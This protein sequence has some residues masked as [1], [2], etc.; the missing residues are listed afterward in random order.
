MYLTWYATSADPVEAI[1][2]MS[3]RR[4][5]LEAEGRMD[6][7]GARTVRTGDALDL[8]NG[9]AD[10]RLRLE[11]EDLLHVGH[12]GLRLLKSRGESQVRVVPGVIAAVGCRSRFEP[13]TW[14]E[15]QLLDR[16]ASAGLEEVRKSDPRPGAMLDAGFD[17]I[18]PLHYPFLDM[19]EAS[20][21]RDRRRRD[22]RRR[23]RS[24]GLRQRRRRL[25]GP[26]ASFEAT[27]DRLATFGI[28]QA[29]HRIVDLGTGQDPCP[30]VGRLR[31]IVTG[32][33]PDI[34]LLR[35]GAGS[36]WRESR[37][38]G[39]RLQRTPVRTAGTDVVTA[40]QCW[41]WFDRRTA[42]A[43]V[44]ASEA[45]DWPISDFAFDWLP[46][47]GNAVAATEALIETHNPAWNMGGALVCGHGGFPMY[48]P[49]DSLTSKLLTDAAVPYSTSWRGRIRASPASPPSMR[50]RHRPLIRRWPRCSV[51]TSS[52]R[53][54]AHRSGNGRRSSA[55]AEAKQ[56][57]HLQ[58]KGP[59]CHQPNRDEPQYC[60]W[61][62]P[63][64]R[65]AVRRGRQVRGYA[66]SSPFPATVW[67]QRTGH[68]AHPRGR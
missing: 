5:E 19:I 34:R 30:A 8:V 37:S 38:P 67:P 33:D 55:G 59:S 68:R 50:K 21:L 66:S 58:H 57:A 11:S 31:R 26:S 27:F 3:A 20:N 54:A 39:T 47:P 40:G 25:C 13:D 43:E 2:V 29:G 63:L 51:A 46:L 56:L 4:D 61:R 6:G 24:A 9:A 53:S 12:A 17:P 28:G 32:I 64:L 7:A 65:N 45:G 62:H 41:H 15:L 49:A 18:R 10:D 42:I 35:Q 44:I 60:P 48:K 1:G 36:P 14:L 52:D 16:E 22:D 23:H